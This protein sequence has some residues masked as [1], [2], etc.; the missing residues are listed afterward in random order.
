MRGAEETR[1]KKY[2]T[3]KNIRYVILSWSEE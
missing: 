2:K 1:I 3:R